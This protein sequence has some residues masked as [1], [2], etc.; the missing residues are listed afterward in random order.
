MPKRILYFLAAALLASTAYA[1]DIFPPLGQSTAI[2]IAGETDN[3]TAVTVKVTEEG[4]LI[5]SSVDGTS[6]GGSSAPVPPTTYTNFGSDNATNVKASA[7]VVFSISAS[8]SNPTE[9]RYLLLHDK[10]T[11]PVAT[12]VPLLPFLVPSQAQAIYGTDFFTDGGIEFSTGIGFCY[13]STED[14]CTPAPASE[15]K[16]IINYE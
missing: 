12:D 5:T 3:N 4:Y 2:G 14:E 13:S 6:G 9:D 15:A 10:A 8:N 11:S 1:A 16:V 7:G